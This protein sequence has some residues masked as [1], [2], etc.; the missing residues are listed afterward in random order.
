MTPEPQ[1]QQIRGLLFLGALIFL[2]VCP[3]GERW[4]AKTRCDRN[5]GSWSDGAC[6]YDAQG[7]E[8]RQQEPMRSVEDGFVSTWTGEVYDSMVACWMGG[9]EGR[10]TAEQTP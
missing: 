8:L 1:S 2:V 7:I 4:T 3:L 6:T 9:K 10:R 5:G